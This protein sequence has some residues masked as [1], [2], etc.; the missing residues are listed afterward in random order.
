MWYYLRD[1]NAREKHI[2]RIPS[3]ADG[4]ILYEYKIYRIARFDRLWNY[5]SVPTF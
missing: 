3:G 2:G 4:K 5:I 1:N